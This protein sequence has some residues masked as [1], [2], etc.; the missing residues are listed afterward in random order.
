MDDQQSNVEPIHMS[1]VAIMIG[2]FN[3]QNHQPIKRVAII[4]NK[5]TK[6]HIIYGVI[7]YYLYENIYV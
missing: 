1:L 6:V 3:C 2:Q 4:A 5:G 7:I